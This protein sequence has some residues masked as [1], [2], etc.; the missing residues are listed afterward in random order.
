MHWL[1]HR[2]LPAGHTTLTD[3]GLLL[4]EAELFG[5]QRLAVQIKGAASTLRCLGHLAD[6]GKQESESEPVG[7]CSASTSASDQELDKLA[8]AV[9][10]TLSILAAE[11]LGNQ[12]LVMTR[13]GDQEMVDSLSTLLQLMVPYTQPT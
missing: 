7:A 12:E 1:H 3:L 5:L 11:V 13:V 4:E 8:G 2:E 10:P 9:G 6:L